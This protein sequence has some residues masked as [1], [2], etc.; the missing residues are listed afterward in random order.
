MRSKQQQAKSRIYAKTSSPSYHTR[1]SVRLEKPI[2]FD[3][4][5][6]SI[7]YSTGPRMR[8]QGKFHTVKSVPPKQKDLVYDP[9]NPPRSSKLPN[10][11]SFRSEPNVNMNLNS[12]QDNKNID[13]KNDVGDTK[14]KEICEPQTRPSNV[15]RGR[16]LNKIQQSSRLSSQI[17]IHNMQSFGIGIGSESTLGISKASSNILDD[18]NG[19]ND[20]AVIKSSSSSNDNLASNH[21]LSQINYRLMV[22]SG[23]FECGNLGYVYRTGLYEYEISMLPDSSRNYSAHWYFFRVENVP[24]GTYTFTITGIFRNLNLH[25]IGVLPVALSMNSIKNYA[26]NP[27]TNIDPKLNSSDLDLPGWQRYGSNL[28]FYRT[29]K[30]PSPRFSLSFSFSVNSIEPDTLYFAYLYPYTYSQLKNFLAKKLPPQIVSSTLCKTPGGIDYP[31][32]FWDADLQQCVDVKLILNGCNGTNQSNSQ[33]SKYVLNYNSSKGRPFTTPKSITHS[34]SSF[35]PSRSIKPP[36]TAPPSSSAPKKTIKTVITDNNRLLTLIKTTTGPKKPLIVFTARHHPGETCA[37]YAMEGFLE[38]LFSVLFD[39]E[40]GEIE[41]KSTEDRKLYSDARRLL[42]SFSFLILPMMNIDGV[43]CGYFR[44]CLGGYDMNRSWIRPCSKLYP[45][46]ATVVRLIDRLVQTRP[47]LFFLDF[48]GHSSQCNAFTY[49]VWNDDVPFNEY[50]AVFPQLMAQKTDLFDDENSIS[51][52][53]ESY[54]QTMRVALHHRYKIPFAYTLEMS[55]GGMNAGSRRGT[56]FSQGGYREIG[57]A[58]VKAL[59]E[60][61][62]DH[63]PTD[64]ITRNYTPPVK[65]PS[66]Q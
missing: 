50:E 4:P 52:A 64:R 5:I 28:N 54:T 55:Y 8:Y 58:S 7:K 29:K 36:T 12:L 42:H 32:I 34:S 6:D 62:M 39:H 33:A 63:I 10:L 43:V 48:H 14:Q 38:S 3:F 56:Q 24:P 47:L 23:D 16:R 46:E 44:H 22:F 17:K 37:S 2:F 1:P 59:A 11:N 66:S 49:G 35:N 25:D 65:D 57:Q 53:R 13:Q 30:S 27:T 41:S 26:N 51:L 9:F 21:V 19:D 18:N 31:A 40:E 60:M 15:C 61:L 20:Q 45:V